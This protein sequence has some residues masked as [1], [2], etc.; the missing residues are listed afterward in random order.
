MVDRQGALNRVGSELRRLG[1]D[2]L[3]CRMA[4]RREPLIAYP[5]P[6]AERTVE[7]YPAKAVT[8]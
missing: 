4:A 6:G 3:T 7:S 1:A 5:P 8:A 2:E